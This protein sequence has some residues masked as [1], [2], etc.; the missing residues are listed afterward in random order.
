MGLTPSGG[1]TIDALGDMEARKTTR[2]RRSALVVAEGSS[3]GVL[4]LC[5]KVQRGEVREEG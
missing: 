4:A 3:I 1:R 5:S 2:T